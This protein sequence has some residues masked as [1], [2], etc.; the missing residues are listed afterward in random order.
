MWERTFVAMTVLAGGTTD[1]GLNLGGGFKMY[2][3][4]H[5]GGRWDA[6]YVMTDV[7]L[8]VHET[9]MNLEATF[10]LFF[11]FGGDWLDT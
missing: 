5:F 10:G 4:E 1:L 2:W 8:P 6:R 7:G 11:A 9:A 3:G